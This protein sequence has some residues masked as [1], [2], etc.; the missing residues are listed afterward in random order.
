MF[1]LVK[2]S[3]LFVK[4]ST[5]FQY[6]TSEIIFS[7][8]NKN[9]HFSFLFN[10]IR[11]IFLALSCACILLIWMNDEEELAFQ[12]IAPNQLYPHKDSYCVCPFS[13]Q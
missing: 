8:L 13:S 4:N 12:P 9:E 11:F 6:N 3:T 10:I 5:N 7:L 2:I 1:E